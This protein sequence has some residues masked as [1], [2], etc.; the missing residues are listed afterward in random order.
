M[1]TNSLSRPERPPRIPRLVRFYDPINPVT[2]S[3][4][5]TL[6]SI[7]AWDDSDLELCHD[8]IQNLF[9]LPERSLFNPS[10]PIINQETFEAF[11]SRPELRARLK[12]S[13]VRILKFYG[14][15]LSSTNTALEVKLASNF[16]QA[17]RNWV[18]RF[19]HNHLRITRIIRSLRVLGLEDEARAFFS[20]L[21]KVH[22]ASNISSKSLMFW[23][24]AAER[25][26]YIAPDDE[27]DD[28]T[29]PDYLYKYEEDKEAE[30]EVGERN[31]MVE[32]ET[33]SQSQDPPQHKNDLSTSIVGTKRKLEDGDEVAR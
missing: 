3:S 25:P 15:K 10:A 12:E 16:G 2:D 7:L 17:S 19:N 28:G 11:R 21:Q 30:K 5:R 27:E 14:F 4:G 6:S 22:A 18:T 32:F 31:K 9:P 33:S 1:F 24:R 23:T 20:T 8:Y 26:L 29:A 13:F